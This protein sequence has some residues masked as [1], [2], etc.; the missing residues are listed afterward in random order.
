M[1]NAFKG[2]EYGK[3]NHNAHLKCGVLLH[4]HVGLLYTNIVPGCTKQT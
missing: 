3:I 1:Y 4:G 2:V